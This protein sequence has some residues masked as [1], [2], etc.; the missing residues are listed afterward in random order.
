M[1]NKKS[2]IKFLLELIKVNLIWVFPISLILIVFIILG[3]ARTISFGNS[4]IEQSIYLTIIFLLSIVSFLYESYKK[5]NYYL[6][7][8]GISSN[9]KISLKQAKIEVE[10][11]SS[12]VK[13]DN[14]SYRTKEFNKQLDAEYTIVD[15]SY[16]IFPLKSKKIKHY[17]KPKIVSDTYSGKRFEIVASKIEKSEDEIVFYLERN[18]SNIQRISL[19]TQ[20]YNS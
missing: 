2:F 1:T 17:L 10:Y 15:N 13:L 16:Y 5:Y 20:S 8:E 11:Y 6:F 3:M 12:L 4:Y 19:K 14:G 9:K 18:K 7:Y